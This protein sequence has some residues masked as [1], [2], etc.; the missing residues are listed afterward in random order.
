MAALT[1]SS[2][3]QGQLDKVSQL[4]P[5]RLSQVEIKEVNS[6]RVAIEDAQQRPLGA[7]WVLSIGN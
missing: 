3:T 5:N 2:E 4:S 6:A 7:V 1:G